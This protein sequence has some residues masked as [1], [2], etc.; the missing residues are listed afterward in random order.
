MTAGER[1]AALAFGAVAIELAKW[2]GSQ[3]E[4]P[5]P[6]VPSL[7]GFDQP[8]A[9]A[10]ALR[11]E[12]GRGQ[13]SIP[14]MVHLLESHGVRVFSLPTSS[15]SVDAFSLWHRDVPY[16]FLNTAKSGEHGRMDAAHELGHLTLHR[17]GGSVRNRHAEIEAQ[18]FA[19]AFLM[20]QGSVLGCAPRAPTIDKLISLKR[21]WS[22]SLIALTHRLHALKLLSDWQYRTLCIEISERGFRKS[23]PSGI[24]RETSQV[25]NKVFGILHADGISRGSVARAVH[26][27]TAELEALI[28]GLVIAAVPGGRQKSTRTEKS[29]RPQLRLI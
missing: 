12:W 24:Q 13:R 21:T 9:A 4:L 8:E 7:R 18:R 3:F 27:E 1:D 10:E 6:D 16:V 22:V 14:N 29:P 2:I 17:H 11:A 19:S 25:L 5:I 15:T 23:E 28:F 26:I 20:P